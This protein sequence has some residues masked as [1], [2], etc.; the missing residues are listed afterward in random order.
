M[1]LIDMNQIMISNLMMQLKGDA[2]N[3]NLVRHM[4]LTALRAFERQYSP[5]FLSTNRIERKTEKHLT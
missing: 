2:L 5:F 1:I 4:V 3:E